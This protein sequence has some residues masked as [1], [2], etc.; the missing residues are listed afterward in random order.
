LWD[1]TTFGKRV[2][3]SLKRIEDLRV[4]CQYGC[5]V[6]SRKKRTPMNVQEMV[7]RWVPI[8]RGL[9]T[10]HTKT[11]LDKC[12]FEMEQHMTPLL[13]APVKQLRE[14]YKELVKALKADPTIPLFVWASFNAWWE[15]VV[16]D[17]PDGAVVELK[18]E[19]ANEIAELVEKDVAPDIGKAIA[20][21]LQWRPAERLEK[22]RDA[23]KRGAKP[24][25]TGRESCLFLEVDEEQVML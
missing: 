11:E 20:S 7:S 23:V 25:L 6:W 17:A 2:D 22:V 8:I 24:K 13:A 15:V 5:Q 18:K 14:F 19:L 3:R 4:L 1:V 16:K 21:A 10:A 9:S 12:E